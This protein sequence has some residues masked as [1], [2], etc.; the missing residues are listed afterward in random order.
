MR[1]MSG[2][3][4]SYCITKDYHPFQGD[5]IFS[6]VA[7]IIA[8]WRYR[9]MDISWFMRCLNES[10]TCAANKEDSCKGR[11]WSFL[12]IHV[13]TALGLPTHRRSRTSCTLRHLGVLPIGRL[14]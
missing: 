6:V 9:L 4:F 2:S 3:G 8:T 5:R 11:F 14:F 10:I 12:R 7:E 13:L 1:V